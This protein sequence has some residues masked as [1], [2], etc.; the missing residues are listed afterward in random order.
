M[1]AL[2]PRV[3]VDAIAD[4]LWRDTPP[5]S[6][7]ATVHTLGVAAAAHL[8]GGGRGHH[9][10]VRESVGRHMSSAALLRAAA[11]AV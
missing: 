5:A 6:V 2:S 7:A 3:T 9:D 8:P 1:L 4:A 10:P 11:D